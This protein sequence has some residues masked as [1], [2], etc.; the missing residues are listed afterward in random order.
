MS[1]GLPRPCWKVAREAGSAGARGVEEARAVLSSSAVL[2]ATRASLEE[3][4]CGARRG[5]GGCSGGGSGES[6]SSGSGSGSGG[7]GRAEARVGIIFWGV[8]GG[9][10]WAGWVERGSRVSAGSTSVRATGERRGTGSWGAE[11]EAEAEAE[12]VQKQCRHASCKLQAA[13]G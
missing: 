13:R 3:L 5:I 7:G 6:G 1:S 4:H 12:V 2:T 8:I 10:C 11:A 9:G